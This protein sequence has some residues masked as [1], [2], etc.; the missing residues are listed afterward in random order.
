MAIN[1]P[2]SLFKTVEQ[3]YNA[4]GAV[5]YDR[6]P[7]GGVN[8]T[9]LGTGTSAATISSTYSVPSGVAE[10]LA[11]SPGLATTADAAGDV[12]FA[13][14]DIVGS[15]FKKVPCQLPFPVGSI[16]LSVGST[17]MQP[18]T[19]W[20]SRFPVIE[21]DEYTWR[22]TPYVAN[23]HNMKG[24]VDLMYSTIPTGKKPIYSQMSTAVQAFDTAGTNTTDSLQLTAADE[25][26][27]LCTVATSESAA[28]A[29]EN[30]IL[31]TSVTGSSLAP[32]QT[33][34]YGVETMDTIAATSGD[35]GSRGL[36]VVPM[37]GYRF[38]TANPTLAFSENLDVA[39]T[40]NVNVA[41]LVRYTQR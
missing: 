33:I 9:A 10:L 34:N 29:Q 25:L 12:K 20:E 3:I 27:E 24:W 7:A 32:F 11:I 39:T 35:T 28:V 41:H 14:M 2:P 40:H 17:R 1:I 31:N 22:G 21:G 15:S 4:G 16:V 6:V 13:F 8:A 26:V 23:S 38:S 19:W 18:Q 30:T 37:Y 5:Y 36:N